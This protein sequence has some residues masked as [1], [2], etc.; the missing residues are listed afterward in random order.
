MARKRVVGV[1]LMDAV[2][3]LSLLFLSIVLVL[4]LLTSSS[5]VLQHAQQRQTAL[6]LARSQMER[7]RGQPFSSLRPGEMPTQELVSLG[8][9]YRTE[10][11]LESSHQGEMLMAQCKV[12]WSSSNR[13]REVSYA[14]TI[15]RP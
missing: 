13:Q 2:V 14:S 3:S 6:E 4:N 1:A 15:L 5:F 8:I 11:T 12:T 7:L 9:S 10:V